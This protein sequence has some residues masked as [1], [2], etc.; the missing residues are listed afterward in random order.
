MDCSPL[1]SFVHGILQARILDPPP[2][3][4]PNLEIKPASPTSALAGGFFFF[5]F[6]LPPVPPVKPVQSMTSVLT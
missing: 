6:F 1:G 4:R 5:F 3:D 2:G